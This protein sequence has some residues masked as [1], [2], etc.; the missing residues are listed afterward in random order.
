M[1]TNDKKITPFKVLQGM[2][3][4]DAYARGEISAPYGHLFFPRI[5]EDIS[6]ACY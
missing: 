2:V 1:T 3:Y 4:H 6:I 5:L